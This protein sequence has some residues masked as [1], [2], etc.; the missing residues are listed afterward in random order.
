MSPMEVRP[1]DHRHAGQ[2][3]KQNV[4]PK[5]SGMRPVALGG[6]WAT[7]SLYPSRII[8]TSRSDF[9]KR[10]IPVLSCGQSPRD[11]QPVMQ[12]VFDITRPR[13]YEALT[14]R[15]QP[16]AIS[17]REIARWNIFV[18]LREMRS[19]GNRSAPLTCGAFLPR[20]SYG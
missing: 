8:P 19:P 4:R 10:T 13:N 6:Q 2:F 1:G 18:K 5:A 14:V 16:V 3:S 17:P 7:D 15:Q 9:G 12:T 11:G 20:K